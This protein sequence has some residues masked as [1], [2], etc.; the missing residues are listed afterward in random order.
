MNAIRARWGRLDVAS[1]RATFV[2]GAYAAVWLLAGVALW[3]LTGSAGLFGALV[4]LTAAVTFLCLVASLAKRIFP[5]V[6]DHR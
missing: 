6:K 3:V 4:Y 5:D 2:V 1:K